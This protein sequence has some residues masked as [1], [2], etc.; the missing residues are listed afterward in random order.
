MATT[1]DD[2]PDNDDLAPAAATAARAA[3]SSGRGEDVGAIGAMKEGGVLPT[4]WVEAEDWSG[5]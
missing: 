5:R 3:A 2:P 4:I 1:E